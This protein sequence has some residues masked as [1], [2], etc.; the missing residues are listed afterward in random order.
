MGIGVRVSPGVLTKEH[1]GGNG[2]RERAR[3]C[4]G[5]RG[6]LRVVLLYTRAL[7]VGDAEQRAHRSG[8]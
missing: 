3:E 5:H 1:G 6:E 7:L 8:C 2:D 4:G